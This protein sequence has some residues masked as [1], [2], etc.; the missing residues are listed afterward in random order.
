M[1]DSNSHAQT[2]ISESDRG[3]FIENTNRIY[4][5]FDAQ[6]ALIVAFMACFIY[7]RTQKATFFVT[8]EILMIFVI[9]ISNIYRGVIEIS[10][11]DEEFLTYTEITLNYI[12]FNCEAQSYFYLCFKYWKSSKVIDLMEK[13]EGGILPNTKL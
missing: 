4:R 9:E 11:S 3:K 1:D 10:Q 8:L 5:I 13:I 7:G 2:L 6:C 12:Y